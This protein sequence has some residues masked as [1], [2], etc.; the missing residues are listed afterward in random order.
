MKIAEVARVHGRG[1]C[2]HAYKTGISVAASIHFLAAI[3]NAV[4][5]E[6]SVSASPLR[7]ETT[8]EKFPVVNGYVD[9]P[10]TPGL[11]V[12]LNMNTVEKY[13]QK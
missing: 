13:R 1:V 5:L 7:N 8:V 12:T 11:G 3:S 4:V 2:N 6:Y 9:V 10:Q